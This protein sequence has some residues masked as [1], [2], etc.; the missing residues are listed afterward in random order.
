MLAR[1]LHDHGYAETHLHLGAAM[2]FPLLWV[3]VLHSLAD[4]ALQAESFRSPGATHDEGGDLG[5]W[6]VRAAL[7]R[8]LLAAYLAWGCPRGSFT[9]FLNAEARERLT[10]EIGA[11]AFEIVWHGLVELQ[12]GVMAAPDFAFSRWQGLYAQLTGLF[13]DLGL[14]ALS[15]QEPLIRFGRCS[16]DTGPKVGRRATSS[17]LRWPTWRRSIGMSLRVSPTDPIRSSPPCFGKWYACGRCFTA[18]WSSVP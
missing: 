5:P 11:G 9:N 18:T 6:L 8:Y 16:L 2:D 10:R 15:R 17:P 4:P 7:A 1:H 12:H 14:H 13:G 3:A